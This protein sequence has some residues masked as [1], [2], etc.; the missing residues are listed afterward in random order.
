MRNNVFMSELKK[1]V[2]NW[3]KQIGPREAARK[4]MAE[5]VSPRAAEGLCRGVY[6]SEPKAIRDKLI[7]AMLKDGFSLAGEIAS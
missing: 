2:R 4:L 3:A 7:S 6:P 1:T 5:G